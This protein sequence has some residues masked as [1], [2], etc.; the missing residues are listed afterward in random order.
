MGALLSPAPLFVTERLL[1]RPW[2]GD[3]AAA[4]A[5]FGHPDVARFSGGRPASVA[6]SRA[7]LERG[8]SPSSA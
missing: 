2:T 3:D 8:L 7:N 5:I 4:F 6:A 1:V